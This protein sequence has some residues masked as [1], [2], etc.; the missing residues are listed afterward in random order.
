MTDNNRASH[1]YNRKWRRLAAFV[2]IAAL[3]SLS[4]GIGA[5]AFATGISGIIIS[6]TGR[7]RRSLA[8]VPHAAVSKSQAAQSKN[9]VGDEITEKALESLLVV[10]DLKTTS[11]L[12]QTLES[13]PELAMTLSDLNALQI[14]A[15]KVGRIPKGRIRRMISKHPRLLAQALQSKRIHVCMPPN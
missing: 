5:D 1:N 8:S 10:W 12:Q 4:N 14:F 13:S 7:A 2:V 15:N 9:V 6:E 3:G 11:K